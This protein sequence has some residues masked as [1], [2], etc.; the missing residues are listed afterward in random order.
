MTTY[1]PRLNDHTT[2]EL[3]DTYRQAP[4]AAVADELERRGVEL[5]AH[6][7]TRTSE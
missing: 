7:L 1:Q 3:L 6:G 2:Q 4:T 5:W